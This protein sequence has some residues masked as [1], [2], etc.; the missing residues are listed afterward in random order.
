MNHILPT[1]QIMN[2]DTFDPL[3]VDLRI[4]GIVMKLREAGFSTFMSCQGRITGV[5]QHAYY[6]PIVGILMFHSEVKKV[7]DFLKENR[8]KKVQINKRRSAL[9]GTYALETNGEYIAI[10]GETLLDLPS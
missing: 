7:K 1:K 10:V 9:N 4:K 2:D 5:P 8:L 3:K 6:R